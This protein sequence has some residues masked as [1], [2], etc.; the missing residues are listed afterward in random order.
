KLCSL[1]ILYGMQVKGLAIYSGQ[2]LEVSTRILESHRRVYKKFWEWTDEVLERALLKGFVQTCYGWKFRAPWKSSKPNPNNRKGVPV[3]TIRNFPVQATAAEM[4]R[5]ACCLIAERGVR[6][7][8]LVHDAVLIE[9]PLAEIDEAVSIT[10]KAMGEASREVLKGRLE[11]RTDAKIFTNR[12]TDERG[13]A[14]WET[15]N[16][17]LQDINHRHRIEPKSEQLGLEL[18]V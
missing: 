1:G 8:A 7:C 14:M 12:Y 10:R 17:L 4:F 18:E 6:L 2:T 3:R 11:L 9:A 15:V 5:L 16:R 13:Q